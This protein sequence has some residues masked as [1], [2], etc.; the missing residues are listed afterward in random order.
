MTE[1]TIIGVTYYHGLKLDLF[2]ESVLLQTS[3]DWCLRVYH[4]GPGDDAYKKTTDRFLDVGSEKRLSF[5]TSKE[6]FNDYG[7]SLREWGLRYVD[8]EYVNFQN[9]DNYLMPRMVEILLAQATRQDLDLLVFPIV[10]NYPNVNFRNDPP[11]S[12][13]D[14]RPALYCCDAGSFIIRTKIAKEVGWNSKAYAADGI[15]IEEVMKSGLVKKWSKC[16]SI[17]MVHN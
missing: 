9:C 14:V 8:S 1:L 15:F 7:H 17:L 6:R 16:P 12:V 13:L 5:S 11:Y 10:H 4:D 2:V 3:P